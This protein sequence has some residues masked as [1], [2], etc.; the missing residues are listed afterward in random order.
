MRQRV[1]KTSA[2]TL[3][4]IDGLLQAVGDLDFPTG[5][6]TLQLL[7]VI[8]LHRI[9]HSGRGHT[10]RNSQRIRRVRPSIGEIADENH[11]SAGWVRDVDLTIAAVIGPFNAVAELD[12]KRLQFV[13]AAVNVTDDV[14]RTVIAAFIGPERL[15][16]DYCGFNVFDAG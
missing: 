12:Q 9:S 11:L 15:T 5:Q 8:A 7:V 16:R 1:A 6:P 3:Q 2:L 10:H 4:L 13:G 14:K